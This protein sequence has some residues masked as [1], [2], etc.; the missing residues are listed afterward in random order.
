[1]P[2]D[3]NSAH[4]EHCRVIIVSVRNTICSLACG[5]LGRTV[6]KSC[7]VGSINVAEFLATSNVT[8]VET[9]RVLKA[10]DE[11]E[12]FA[13]EKLSYRPSFAVR[14]RATDAST[15]WAKAGSS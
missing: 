9:P 3:E 11:G 6:E 15:R 10:V 14:M 13:I 2:R 1:M 5:G 4:V 12:I 8:S 7:K